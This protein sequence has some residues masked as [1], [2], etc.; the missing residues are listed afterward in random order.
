MSRRRDTSRP[1]QRA[2]RKTVPKVQPRPDRPARTRPASSA[3]RVNRVD[4]VDRVDRFSGPA[5]GRTTLPPRSRSS[6]GTTAPPTTAP[7]TAG[8]R[9][10]AR[11]RQATPAV[12]E[13]RARRTPTTR[14]SSRAHSTSVRRSIQRRVVA[15]RRQAIHRASRFGIGQARYRLIAMLIVI[16]FVLGMVLF[17]VARLQTSNGEVFRIEGAEQWSRSTV[18]AA[19]RG[20]IFD[21]N[22][23]ELAVSVPAVTISV[24]PKLVDDEAATATMLQQTL[25]LT[26]EE[27]SELLAALIAK[28]TG[29]RYV[30]RQVDPAIGE[31]LRAL[32]IEGINV[33]DEDR[34]ILPGGET[35]R[36]VIGLTNIDGTG[37]A[38]LEYQ[39]G[40]GEAAVAD[41]YTD[42]LTGTPGEASREVAPGG[43][44]IAGSEQV[45]LTP[46]PGD[47]LVLTIDRSIQ[48]ATE[49]AL[50]ERVT[51]VQGR[52]GTA[53][54][55]DTDTG[56]IYASASVIRNDDGV[57]EITPGNFA[58]VNAYEPGSVAKVITTAAGLNE[59]AVT[60]ETTFVVPWRRQYADDLLEDSHQH[61]DTQ[62]SVRQIFVESSNIGTIDVQLATGR[63]K[64]YEYM[65][66]FGLGERTA[67]N[68]PGESAGLLKDFDDLWGSER[69]TVAYGQGMASTSMQ[70]VSAINAIAND[71]TYVA[72][73]LLAGT[74]GSAGVIT[75]AQPSATHEVI[76]PEIA[77][78]VQQMMRGVVCDPLGTGELAQRG[79]ENF[80]V[81]GK[82]GTGLKP[83]P[84]GQYED[85]AG[86]R[87]YYA[88][89]VG[90]FPAEDPQVTVLIS[91]DEPSPDT[92]DRFGG[93]AAAPVFA[94]LAPTIVHE[95]GIVPPANSTPCQS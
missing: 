50:L 38:G 89:F 63:E 52:L 48:F 39:Y 87:L 33:D 72:P 49:Q 11:Q 2:V 12:P 69:V 77:E 90:F 26:D 64:H 91:I 23:E 15:P 17:R 6:L 30:R 54:V 58:A 55:M 65:R 36:S 51:E 61:P 28:E 41:G 21:R 74:V 5:D 20:T 71:G 8:Q 35:G 83:H 29:F 34:R 59:G 43:R 53:I 31:Q 1:E 85:A 76:R 14:T 37:V 40:G 62:M 45:T 75:E 10:V 80:S 46:T 66:L 67:L 70:L 78:Q 60:P 81:A 7:R 56:D 57:V 79:I 73:R 93:T 84:D 32:K 16:V 95:L 3:N 94:E 4:R 9:R 27:T 86:N 47:D 68:F 82:T 24:N 25:Q 18:L 22:G 19:D 42:V 88:S 44:S 13:T 92:L